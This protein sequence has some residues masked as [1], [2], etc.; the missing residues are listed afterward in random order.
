MQISSIHSQA[1]FIEMPCVLYVCVHATYGGIMEGK[2]ARVN[3]WRN[4]AGY[5]MGTCW[6]GRV[7]GNNPGVPCRVR[8]LLDPLEAFN[9]HA[10]VSFAPTGVQG[11]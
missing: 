1:D 6:V 7:C 3:V 10:R 8:R 11:C 4:T 2:A 5:T 9:Y